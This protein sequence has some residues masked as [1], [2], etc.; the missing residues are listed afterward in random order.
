MAHVGKIGV[1]G[2]KLGVGW[3]ALEQGPI[4]LAGAQIER[5]HGGNQLPAAVRE[6]QDISDEASI[7]SVG[8][9]TPGLIET[10]DQQVCRSHARPVFKY[11]PERV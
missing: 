5:A 7:V 2:S 10:V 8:R 4:L 3:R 1:A 9:S 11:I 6:S